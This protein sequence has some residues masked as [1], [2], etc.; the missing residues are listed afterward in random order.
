LNTS[1]KFNASTLLSAG[2]DNLFDREYAEFVSRSS[3]N[4]MGG[5][6][7]GY[8]QTMRVNEPGRTLWLKLQTS[9]N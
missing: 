2:A 8:L 9:I 3:G 5:S 6:I 7:P 4:G 1:Y